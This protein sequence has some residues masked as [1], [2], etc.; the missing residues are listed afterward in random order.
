MVADWDLEQFAQ[1]RAAFSGKPPAEAGDEIEE[2][3]D[4]RTPPG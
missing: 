1:A 2:F 4:A 3:L